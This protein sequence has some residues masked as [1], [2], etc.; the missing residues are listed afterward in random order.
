MHRLFA[1]S[2]LVL[3]TSIPPVHCFDDKER[4]K[5]PEI[6]HVVPTW[7]DLTSTNE[8]SV[9]LSDW[10][11][12]VVVVCFTC[13]SCPYSVDYE[14]RLLKLHKKYAGNSS[15]KLVAINSNLI[16]ADSMEK[17]Q[18][19]ASEKGFK[20]PYVK[21]ETQSVAKAWGAVYTPEFFVLNRKHEL[22]FKGAMDDSTKAE[23]VTEHYVSAAV[24]AALA[25]KTPRTTN[26]G[27][28]GCAIRFKR[29]RR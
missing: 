5:P 21:D 24:D 16:S 19:R 14:D 8:Q 10:K 11:D 27:A 9:S 3:L 12:K 2:V 25:G 6:G 17:M 23:N 22:I 7:S 4:P 20:F 28:R 26:V 15:V 18:E 1:I 29:R 13:N